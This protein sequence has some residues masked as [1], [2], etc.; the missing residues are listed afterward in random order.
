MVITNKTHD[1][2][3]ITIDNTRI[4]NVKDFHYL[5]LTLDDRLSFTSHVRLINNKLARL[6]GISRR[7]GNT[8]DMHAAKLFYYSFIYPVVNYG[9]S[10]W[11]GYFMLHIS[12]KTHKLYNKIIRNLFKIHFPHLTS[13][14][15]MKNLQILNLKQSY[16]M[17]ILELCYCIKNYNA[18]PY[19]NISLQEN[20]EPYYYNLRH[21]QELRVPFPR[22]NTIKS[23]YLY[24]MTVLWND[25]PF[26]VRNSCNKRS[27]KLRLKQHLIDH[28]Q[29]YVLH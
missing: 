17:Q 1:D 5:G 19:L 8:F 3:T 27:F 10:V 16:M 18:Y 9:I 4:Q 25:L 14:Q 6:V 22:T 13:Q 11:G 28:S 26:R 29:T 15:I 24:Q 20:D 12:N 7:L 21:T 23:H 2:I